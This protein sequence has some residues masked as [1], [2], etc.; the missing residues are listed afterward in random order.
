MWQALCTLSCVLA[1]VFLPI[2]LEEEIHASLLYRGEQAKKGACQVPDQDIA[3]DDEAGI[4]TQICLTPKTV[5]FPFFLPLVGR[6]GAAR[7]TFP[8]SVVG[9]LG[10]SEYRQ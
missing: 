10:Q 8:S 6:Q 2:H 4:E 3:G 7:L 9:S 5:L 1:R